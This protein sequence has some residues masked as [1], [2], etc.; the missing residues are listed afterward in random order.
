MEENNIEEEIIIDIG[1][2]NIK[3]YSIN[4]MKEIKKYI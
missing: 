1:S 4:K 2:G 3:A